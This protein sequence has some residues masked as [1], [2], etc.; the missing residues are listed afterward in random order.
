M[1]QSL[2]DTHI[3]AYMHMCVCTCDGERESVCVYTG[4]ERVRVLVK[5]SWTL[6]LML[7]IFFYFC[8][9]FRY[10][11]WWMCSLCWGWW[12]EAWAAHG[13]CLWSKHYQYLP[14]S[15]ATLYRN[16]NPFNLR[17][18]NLWPSWQIAANVCVCVCV[19]VW[20]ERLSLKIRNWMLINSV[21]LYI[22]IIMNNVL[23]MCV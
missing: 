16:I 21:S 12:Q 18:V 10:P 19:C 22:C 23:C 3:G 15:M 9:V 11:L 13:Q 4:T 14:G 17:T 8:L 7:P 20:V 5:V 1:Y 6:V 2:C